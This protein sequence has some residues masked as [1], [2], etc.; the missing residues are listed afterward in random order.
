M[1]LHLVLKILVSSF[2]IF[3]NYFAK[4]RIE[5][6]IG[7]GNS[8]RTSLEKQMKDSHGD[9]VL[10]NPPLTQGMQVQSLVCVSKGSHN[11]IFKSETNPRG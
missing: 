9:P 1:I 8:E 3:N 4:C 2:E 7:S 11:Q 5:P 6:W 10:R